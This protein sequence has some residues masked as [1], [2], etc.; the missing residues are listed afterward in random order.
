MTAGYPD[1]VQNDQFVSAF[2]EDPFRQWTAEELIAIGLSVPRVF[3]PGTNWDYSHTNYMILGLAL[4]AATGASLDDLLQQHIIESLGLEGT[5]SVDTA[6]MPQPVLHAFSSERRES[7]NIPPSVGFYE[8]STFWSPSW[9]LAPGA[10][11]YS[12]ITDMARSLEAIGSGELLTEES[13]QEQI[14]QQLLGFGAPLQGCPTCHV[15]DEAYNYGLGI[16]HSGNWLLQNPLF[17]GYG[18][19]A[20]YLPDR[21]IA[22]AVVTTFGEQSFGE[23]GELRY[24]NAS[25]ATFQ[26]IAELL[27]PDDPPL[28]S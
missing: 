22:I 3:A 18:G 16:V 23:A 26:R 9:T 21:K 20:A 12:T 19:T 27:A 15:L 11:Q 5:G 28:L 10:V 17:G 24:G 25:T 1:H 6:W 13:Y 4:E 8:E 7:L 14:G 2:Y